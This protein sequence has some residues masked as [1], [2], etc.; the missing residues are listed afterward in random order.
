MLDVAH[1]AVHAQPMTSREAIAWSFAGVTEAPAKILG[2]EGYG[3]RVGAYADLVVLQAADPIEAV[4]MRAPRL[5]VIRRGRVIASAP[6]RV[7]DL[8][9]PSRPKTLDPADYAPRA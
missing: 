9:L 1:M 6:P 8:D 5:W 3:L 2:L 4:R 7:V